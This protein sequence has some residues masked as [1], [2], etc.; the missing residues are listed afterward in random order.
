VIRVALARRAARAV[1]TRLQVAVSL[2]EVVGSRGS[3]R[4][5]FRTAAWKAACDGELSPAEGK[6]LDLEDP[7]ETWGGG[8][9]EVQAERVLELFASLDGLPRK[10]LCLGYR[11]RAGARPSSPR[12][13][14]LL[15]AVRKAKRFTADPQ[16][17][18]RVALRL[19][20]ATG[21]SQTSY[22]SAPE[23]E[24]LERLLGGRPARK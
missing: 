7:E 1:A 23:H 19:E 5:R 12:V 14:M 20:L 2:F 3:K 17:D 21:G 13:A 24:E 18:G 16:A 11:R 6:E 10:T 22:C 4:F 9:F 8:S 15:S